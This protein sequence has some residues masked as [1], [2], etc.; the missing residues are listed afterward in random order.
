MIFSFNLYNRYILSILSKESKDKA[1]LLN[2]YKNYSFIIGILTII[3]GFFIYMRKLN[4][5]NM[6]M[7][8]ILLHLY[9]EKQ[10]VKA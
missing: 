8:L 4:I 1:D 10:H 6:V 9:L 3:I 7:I 5:K 2:K